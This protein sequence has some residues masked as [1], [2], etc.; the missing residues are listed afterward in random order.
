MKMIDPIVYKQAM[1]LLNVQIDKA[2]RKI[3]KAYSHVFLTDEGQQKQPDV[4]AIIYPEDELESA[5]VS[6]AMQAAAISRHENE[7]F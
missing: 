5:T 7:E 1:L 2:E 4:V 3:E 6:L